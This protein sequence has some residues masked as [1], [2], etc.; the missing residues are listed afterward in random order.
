MLRTIGDQIRGLNDELI[1]I[2]ADIP[3]LQVSTVEVRY[4]SADQA[5]HDATYW[6]AIDQM[7]YPAEDKAEAGG[8]RDKHGRQD[9]AIFRGLCFA[10]FSPLILDLLSVV[11]A[12]G[13]YSDQIAEYL[14]AA[15]HGFTAFW[16]ATCR[17][18]SQCRP[19]DAITQVYYFRPGLKVIISRP[20]IIFILIYLSQYLSSVIKTVL[21]YIFF[22]KLIF[23]FY[24]ALDGLDCSS[25]PLEEPQQAASGAR[26]GDI[27]LTS[28]MRTTHLVEVFQQL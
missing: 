27:K 6:L 15:D 14:S 3:P 25:V 22:N 5:I 2:G 12:S 8:S 21:L 9:M 28:T 13:T 16:T 1:A 26:S 18:R 4:H 20:L 11:G 23:R 24:H 7:T 19:A 10:A 17:V